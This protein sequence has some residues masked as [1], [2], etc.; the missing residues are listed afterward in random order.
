MLAIDTR[1]NRVV[2]II[3]QNS[4]DTNSFLIRSPSG[5]REIVPQFYI[6]ML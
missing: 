3:S 4:S 5:D 6:K 1:N 2:R